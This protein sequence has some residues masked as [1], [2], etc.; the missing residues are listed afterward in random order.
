MLPGDDEGRWSGD[1][2]ERE[3]SCFRDQPWHGFV[4]RSMMPMKFEI[5]YDSCASTL[6][7]AGLRVVTAERSSLLFVA[8]LTPWSTVSWAPS[9]VSLGKTIE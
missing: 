5:R 3:L 9:V 2:A 1:A 4:F 7:D 6:K 8:F